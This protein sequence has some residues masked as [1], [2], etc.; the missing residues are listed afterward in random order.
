MPEEGVGYDEWFGNCFISL[1]GAPGAGPAHNFN[2][3]SICRGEATYAGFVENGAH[4]CV[5]SRLGELRNDPERF[6]SKKWRY[7]THRNWYVNP[8]LA[9]SVVAF[10]WMLHR[11]RVPNVEVSRA[12][13]GATCAL[14]KACLRQASVATIG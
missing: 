6:D 3:K 9:W 12:N 7:L 8:N 5:A 2:L 13:D 11:S 14:H 1:V 10:P 4:L